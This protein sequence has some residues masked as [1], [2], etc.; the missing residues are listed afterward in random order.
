LNASLAGPEMRH[1]NSLK[2]LAQAI[3]LQDLVVEEFSSIL[4]SATS[5]DHV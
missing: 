5:P 3:I 1:V 2:E 4:D